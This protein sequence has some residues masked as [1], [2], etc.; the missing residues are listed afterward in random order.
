MNNKEYKIDS[1]YFQFHITGSGIVAA[2]VLFACIIGILLGLYPKLLTLV[3]VVAGYTFWNTFIAI[4][5]PQVVTISD[6]MVSFSAYGRT[7]CFD[8]C[9]LSSF[10]IR[11]FPS[12][13]K[14]YIR[15]NKAGLLKGRYWI[16]TKMFNDGQELFRKLLEIERNI[17]PESLKSQAY[18]T[19]VKYSEIKQ[20]KEMA[21]EVL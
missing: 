15:V 11:E 12:A 5:N 14:M 7:D 3:L 4:S 6:E 8:L 20:K 18:K 17:H 10:M 1:R 21:K 16:G 9:E 19:S 2:G 13:G